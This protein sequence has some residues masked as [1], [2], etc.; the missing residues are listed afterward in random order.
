MAYEITEAVLRRA[1]AG[2]A[3]A[4]LGP[5][6]RPIA[7]AGGFVLERTPTTVSELPPMASIPFGERT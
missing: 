6:T 7:R 2:A 4:T 3:D 1:D 5:Y